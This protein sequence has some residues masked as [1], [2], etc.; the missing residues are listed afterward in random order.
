ME[1]QV[2]DFIVVEEDYRDDKSTKT[3]INVYGEQMNDS[4]RLAIKIKE[5]AKEKGIKIGDLETKLGLSM[6]YF[7]R[8][9]KQKQA[10]MHFE[11]AV[12]V[13]KEFGM[14]IDEML[15]YKSPLEKLSEDL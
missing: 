5:I 11:T 4:Q 12:K 8:F 7:S 13:A 10:S 9:K 1:L 14:T 2:S 3:L 6:G 15:N